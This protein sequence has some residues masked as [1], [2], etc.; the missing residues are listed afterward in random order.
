MSNPLILLGGVEVKGGKSGWK[1]GERVIEGILEQVYSE[2]FQT[3]LVCNAEEN[4]SPH[5]VIYFSV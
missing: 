4:T 3:W 2:S 1:S 5:I